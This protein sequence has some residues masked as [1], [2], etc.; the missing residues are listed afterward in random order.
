MDENIEAST[1]KYQLDITGMFSISLIE[2]SFV[3]ILI[4]YEDS[5]TT[6]RLW[7]GFSHGG[8][9]ISLLTGDN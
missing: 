4:S 7:P 6:N 9:S 1:R 3:I 5:T 8:T 2:R